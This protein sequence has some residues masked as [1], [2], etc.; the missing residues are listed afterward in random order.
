M[1]KVKVGSQNC[2]ATHYMK[3]AGLEKYTVMHENG[4]VSQL[5]KFVISEECK[6]I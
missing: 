2:G 1:Q 3:H 5:N 4:L 6:L